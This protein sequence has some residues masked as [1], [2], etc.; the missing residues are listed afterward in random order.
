MGFLLALAGGFLLAFIG[1]FVINEATQ[2]LLA[3]LNLLIALTVFFGDMVLVA[4]LVLDLTGK[5]VVGAVL[6]GLKQKRGL[7]SL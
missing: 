2:L 4:K 3:G 1:S 6:L 7:Q 5:L